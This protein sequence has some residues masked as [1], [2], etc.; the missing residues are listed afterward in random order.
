[1]DRNRNPTITL[2][3]IAE[4][5][6]EIMSTLLLISWHTHLVSVGRMSCNIASPTWI[7]TGTRKKRR[8]PVRSPLLILA[9]IFVFQTFVAYKP[10]IKRMNIE[11]KWKYAWDLSLLPF[12]FLPKFLF[13][14]R[15]SVCFKCH[16]S[17]IIFELGFYYFI[18][19]KL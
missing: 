7:I 8:S 10:K 3:E 6:S 2:T 12:A 1:M 5:S 4:W 13:F 16:L 19:S 18:L 15:V 17:Y 14:P 11:K 9:A